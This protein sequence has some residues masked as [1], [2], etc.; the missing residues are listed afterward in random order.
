L[1]LVILA[2]SLFSTIIFAEEKKYDLNASSVIKDIL[3][4][5]TGKRVYLRMDSGE[6]VLGVVSKVGDQLV[7]VSSLAGRDF[8]DAVIRID[9]ITAVIFKVRGN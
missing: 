6:E 1:I 9:R 4:E 3:K 5:Q 8:Y 7:H 2:C